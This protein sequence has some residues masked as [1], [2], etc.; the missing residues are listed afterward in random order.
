MS[1]LS[2]SL[3][4]LKIKNVA[5]AVSKA[6]GS[7]SKA[8]DFLPAPIGTVAK[9]AVGLLAGAG[10]KLNKEQKVAKVAKGSLLSRIPK[11]PQN[12]RLMKQTVANVKTLKSRAK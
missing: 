2:K 3:K 12:V 6:S 8:T 4:K 1:W 7:L 10:K 11:T 5:K 9:G